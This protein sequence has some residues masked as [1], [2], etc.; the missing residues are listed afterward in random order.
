M[1]PN[2]SLKS[3]SCPD[4]KHRLA[5]KLAVTANF[6]PFCLLGSRVCQTAAVSILGFNLHSLPRCASFSH[7][8]PLYPS[9]DP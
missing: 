2:V 7:L 5:A 3:M 4:L 8:L 6:M 1:L 9:R